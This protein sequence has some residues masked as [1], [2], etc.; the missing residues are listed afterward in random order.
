MLKNI[1]VFFRRL[2]NFIDSD[3]IVIIE[4]IGEVVKRGLWSVFENVFIVP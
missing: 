3:T 1:L 4:P 2:D